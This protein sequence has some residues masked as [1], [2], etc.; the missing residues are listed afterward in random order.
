MPEQQATQVTA[1]AIK[2]F[3][4]SNEHL[5]WIFK[6]LAALVIPTMY[7]IIQI[8]S[9]YTQLQTKVE[10]IEK[11]RQEDSTQFKELAKQIN[12]ISINTAETRVSVDFVIKNIK[13]LKVEHN[14]KLT[15]LKNEINTRRPVSIEVPYLSQQQGV[16]K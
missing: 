4:I 1:Q 7:Y 16:E 2:P 8:N 9:N 13:D 6:S 11:I 15:E 14:E 12:N 5:E 10:N 3:L